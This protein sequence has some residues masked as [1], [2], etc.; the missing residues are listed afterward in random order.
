MQQNC[1]ANVEKAG[2]NN[3]VNNAL[4]R[5]RQQVVLLLTSHVQNFQKT[6]LA[7]RRKCQQ[8]A[9]KK[10]AMLRAFYMQQLMDLETSYM[11][12]MAMAIESRTANDENEES[13]NEQ[14]LSCSEQA[15]NETSKKAIVKSILSFI[16]SVSM[17]HF[18]IKMISQIN[19]AQK[20]SPAAMKTTARM[21]WQRSSSR[22]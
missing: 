17:I 20:H 8:R 14:Q 10:Q 5:K 18:N 2:K 7:S 19:R 3:D 21:S 6:L 15:A 1:L 4:Q 16:A 9:R 12:M 11:E 13:D 22:N